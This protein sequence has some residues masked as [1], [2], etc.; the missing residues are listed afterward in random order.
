VAKYRIPTNL[1]PSR[2]DG[3]SCEKTDLAWWDGWG[4]VE[5]QVGR[6][7]RSVAAGAQTAL[8]KRML[9]S[10]PTSCTI[11]IYRSR[12]TQAR[13]VATRGS[14]LGGLVRGV[15]VRPRYGSSRALTADP[16][17]AGWDKVAI[18]RLGMPRRTPRSSWYI[19]NGL[20][21]VSVR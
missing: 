3:L 13:G 6:Q 9:I 12:R 7:R 1:S 5:C 11:V 8:G 18:G 14:A 21:M 19:S 17:C 10:R 4:W 2:R 15:V 16:V 20:E